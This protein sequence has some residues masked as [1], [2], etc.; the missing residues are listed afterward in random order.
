MS[1]YS[2]REYT[3]MILSLGACSGN[4][5]AAADHYRHRY[6]NRQHPDR[7]VIQR[8]KRTLGEYGSFEKLRRHG[9]RRRRVSV[10]ARVPSENSKSIFLKTKPQTKN[11]YSIFSTSFFA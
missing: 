10:S 7:H 5:S 1:T 6:P 11:F 4:A 2:N 3:D 8:A 9:G